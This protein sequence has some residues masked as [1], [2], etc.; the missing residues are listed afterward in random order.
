MKNE[1]PFN[2]LQLYKR[3]FVIKNCLDEALLIAL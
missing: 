1:I 3:T 2:A